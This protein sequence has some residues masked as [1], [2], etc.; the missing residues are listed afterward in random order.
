MNP[1]KGGRW[2]CPSY[3]IVSKYFK[4]VKKLDRHLLYNNFVCNEIEVQVH[5]RLAHKEDTWYYFIV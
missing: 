2:K 1:L 3:E 4:E 5:N